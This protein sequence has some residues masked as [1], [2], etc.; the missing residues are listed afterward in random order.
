MID[1]LAPKWG[2]LIFFPEQ[3]YYGE[4]IP[5]DSMSYLTTQNVLEDYVELL[6]YIKEEYEA[7]KCPV[8]AFGGSYGATLTTFMRAAYPSHVIGGL[9]SSAPTG[10]YDPENWASHGVDEFT[11]ADIISD[12]YDKADPQCLSAISAASDAIEKTRTE[13]L[14][15]AFNL[16]ESSGLGPHKSDLFTYGLVSQNSSSLFSLMINYFF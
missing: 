7:E 1:Y 8:V 14:M 13:E 5:S 4:S 12:S 16:C 3:R 15:Q 2:G 10:Y 11:F 9:A 6:T